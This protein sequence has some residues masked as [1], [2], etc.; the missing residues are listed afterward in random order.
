[1]W[2]EIKQIS[3][4]TDKIRYIFYKPGWLPEDM[5]GYRP[6][7]EV[8]KASY[9]KYKTTASSKLNAYILFQ[10]IAT[11]GLTTWFLV[12]QDKITMLPKIITALVIM[13]TT[14]TSGGLFEMK[15]WINWAEKL[16]LIAVLAIGAYLG[17]IEAVNGLI[18]MYIASYFMFS[19]I[20]LTAALK[21]NTHE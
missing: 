20:W 15:S 7:P 8:N 6:A 18:L 11:L 19:R 16:R 2:Q 14:I 12:N 1:M 3:R 13:I 10:F 5:G 21:N 9:H 17:Y 4:F